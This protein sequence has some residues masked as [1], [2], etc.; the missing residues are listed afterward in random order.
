[1]GSNFSP[2]MANLYLHFYESQFLSRN[3]EEGR[4]R[5]KY[6]YRFI[7]DL[8]SVNNRDI[9]FD[10]RA[11]Y[12]RFLDITN[13]NS[14]SFNNASFLD[15][16]VKVNDNKFSTKVYDKRRDFDF[17]ILGL[18][19]FSSNIPK[20]MAFGIICS[21]FIRFANICM[22][23]EDFIYN[24]Q[25]VIN[26]ISNN[27]FPIWLLKNYVIKFQNRKNRLLTKFNLGRDLHFHFEF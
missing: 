22:V 6:T 25:L 10:V 2:N 16:D 15:I 27:G 12:P 26:K 19:A 14:N 5:Y 8:I 13:T 1:M 21:Q 23:K 9:I 11:I 24:C 18:P 3:H 4:N 20:K 7:D 17:E